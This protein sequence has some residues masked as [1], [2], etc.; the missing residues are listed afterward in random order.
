MHPYHFHHLPRSTRAL[1][2]YVHSFGVP[3]EGRLP[4]GT[5]VQ[6]KKHYITYFYI[7]ET[8][9]TVC[10]AHESHPESPWPTSDTFDVFWIPL[11]IF[12]AEWRRC[13]NVVGE[14]RGYFLDERMEAGTGQMVLSF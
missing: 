14:P 1:V 5:F 11:A 9:D 2:D 12:K 4:F 13:L 8:A 6:M 7:C 3:V 10:L